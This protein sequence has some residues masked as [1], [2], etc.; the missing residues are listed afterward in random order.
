MNRIKYGGSRQKTREKG[1]YRPSGKQDGHKETHTTHKASVQKPAVTKARN[2]NW[3]EFQMR[4][5][6]S[7]VLSFVLSL[8]WMGFIVGLV[9]MLFP[10]ELYQQAGVGPIMAQ[11]MV[12]SAQSA[13]GLLVLLLVAVSNYFGRAKLSPK[14]AKKMSWLNF[15]DTFFNRL[16]PILGLM[17]V[18]VMY[19][20]IPWTQDYATD[21][22]YLVPSTLLWL[23]FFDL[24]M[25]SLSEANQRP[26]RWIGQI[27]EWFHSPI[28]LIR[29]AIIGLVYWIA[30][31]AFFKGIVQGI[32]DNKK[33]RREQRASGKQKKAKGQKQKQDAPAASTLDE[34]RRLQ[35]AADDRERSRKKREAAQKLEAAKKQPTTSTKPFQSLTGGTIEQSAA[36]AAKPAQPAKPASVATTRVEKTPESSP[37]VEKKVEAFSPGTIDVIQQHLPALI[38]LRK[39]EQS[40][41][42]GI[43]EKATNDK[44]F[45]GDVMNITNDSNADKPGAVEDR[46]IHQGRDPEAFLANIEK[47]LEKTAVEAN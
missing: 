21:P 17:F 16:S 6:I 37:V 29:A 44:G 15:P 3:N 4:W 14:G 26:I 35:Q 39:A 10:Q 23:Y 11:T 28:E 32:R 7:Q 12:R 30:W 36:E 41:L 18:V 45:A 43:I 40:K 22:V 31:R 47:L 38:A 33:E 25:R 20:F 46:L 2:R 24:T 9:L 34:V 1:D 42:Y 8:A 13:I 5:A 19:N 27:F